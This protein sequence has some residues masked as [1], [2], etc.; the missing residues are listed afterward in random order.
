MPLV[1]RIAF[2][3]AWI[4]VCAGVGLAFV[5][6]VWGVDPIFKWPEHFRS[7]ESINELRAEYAR[8]KLSEEQFEQNPGTKPVRTRDRTVEETRGLANS[9]YRHCRRKIHAP[10][11]VG[12]TG[13][14]KFSRD[15]VSDPK[16]LPE[17]TKCWKF[18]SRDVDSW[19]TGISQD[20]L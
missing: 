13:G 5:C 10:S 11:K 19:H 18:V 8:G 9:P 3:L 17:T 20:C 12:D 4:I 7:R 14:G 15:W 16:L 2:G 6:T 1:D